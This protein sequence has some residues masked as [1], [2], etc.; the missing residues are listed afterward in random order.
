MNI[1][2]LLLREYAKEYIDAI[3]MNVEMLLLRE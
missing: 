2:M 3:A 1:E